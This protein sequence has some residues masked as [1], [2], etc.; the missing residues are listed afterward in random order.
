MGKIILFFQVFA[1]I[2]ISGIAQE[3]DDQK[4]LAIHHRYLDEA[5]ELTKHCVGFSPPV[6]GRAFAYLSVGIYE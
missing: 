1:L 5:I 4:V 3:S 2:S 6:S